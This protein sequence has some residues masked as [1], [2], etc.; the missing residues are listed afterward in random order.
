MMVQVG[1]KPQHVLQGHVV[2]SKLNVNEQAMLEAGL[3][4]KWQVSTFLEQVAIAR[5]APSLTLFLHPPKGDHKRFMAF[6][7]DLHD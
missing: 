4:Y 1:G 6:N 2:V 5:C 3:D 7:I